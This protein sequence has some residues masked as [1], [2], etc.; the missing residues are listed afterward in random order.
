MQA[1]QHIDGRALA[2]IALVLFLALGMVGNVDYEE[3][4]RIEAERKDRAAG[5]A[6]PRPAPIYSRR[7]HERGQTTLGKQADGG[8]WI[9]YC[10]GP[11]TRT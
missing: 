1:P 10:T 9:V 6:Q 3:Q 8:E 2:F 4:K 5:R 7:C 11:R